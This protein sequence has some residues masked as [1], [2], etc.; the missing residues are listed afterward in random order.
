[1]AAAPDEAQATI[2]A[3]QFAAQG[4]HASIVVIPSTASDMAPYVSQASSSSC[5]LLTGTTPSETTQ[6]SVALRQAPKKFEHII[7]TPTLTTQ[8]T[9]A[10][11]DVWNG[12]QVV[13][14]VSNY[15]APAWAPFRDAVA[16]YGKLNDKSDPYSEAQGNWLS[17]TLLGTVATS[18]ANEGVSITAASVV[19]ALST[20][21]KWSTANLSPAVN[22]T[23]KLSVPDAPRLVSPYAAFSVVTNGKVVG[24]FNNQYRS[25][26]PIILRRPVSSG[27]GGN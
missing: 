5:L 24:A 7:A 25:V 1:M 13:S 18:L 15:D 26:L 12:A 17:M 11:P 22:F 21:T 3:Q 20:N 6:L 10:A 14:F 16:K 19:K 8:I 2:Q 23:T 27:T 4:R 9:S